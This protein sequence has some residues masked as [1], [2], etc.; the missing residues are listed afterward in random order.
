[1]D[2][3]LFIKNCKRL[4]KNSETGEAAS[5]LK[6]KNYMKAGNAELARVHAENAIRHRQVAR[7]YYTLMAN[8]SPLEFELKKQLS[9]RVTEYTLAIIHKIDRLKIDATNLNTSKQEE[10]PALHINAYIQA[11][12]EDIQLDMLNKLPQCGSTVDSLVG[13]LDNLRK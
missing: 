9:G 11:L 8:A 10:V 3:R 1:M 5:K 4:A 13:R 7:Y 12:S 2:L 6:A